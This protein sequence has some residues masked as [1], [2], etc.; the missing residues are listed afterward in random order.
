MILMR[1]FFIFGWLSGL[2]RVF[3]IEVAGTE[4]LD[5]Y[6]GS[7]TALYE[8]FR[9]EV[10]NER[11]RG[12]WVGDSFVYR[13]DEGGKRVY[14]SVNVKGVKELAFDH[15]VMARLISEITGNE[16]KADR[17]PIRRMRGKDGGLQIWVSKKWYAW[18]EG[19]GKL[20]RVKRKVRGGEGG[21]VV[22]P[23]GKWSVRLLGAGVF[24]RAVGDDG[25]GERVLFQG[26]AAEF[27]FGGVTWSPDSK[28]FIVGR[29]AVVEGRKVSF[30]E[31]SPEG[32]LQPKLHEF[33]YDK[34]G[35]KISVTVPWVYFVDGGEVFAPDMELLE[36]PYQ[37][38][39]FG[40]RD[41]DRFTYEFIERG[42]GKHHVIL[43][44]VVAR[45]HVVL[46]REDSETYVHA[47]GGYRYD[48]S[49]GKEIIWSSERDGWRHLYLYDG[50][51]GRVKNQITK[52]EMTLHEVVHVDEVRRRI[53][54]SA[55]GE[56]R[57]RDPYYKHYYWVNFDGGGLVRVT[58]GQDNHE[59]LFS[60]DYRYAVD[61]VCGVNRAP[62][63]RVIDVDTGE[64]MVELGDCDLGRIRD[65]GWQMP[66]PFMAKDRDGR[67]EVWGAI[68]RPVGF[69][70]KKKYP[71][72]EYIYAGP[73]D[74]H[75]PKV[76]RF[77]NRGIHEL[78]MRGFL[79]VRID[80]KGTNKRCR[81]FSHFCYKNIV[82]AG[83]PDRIKWIREAGKRYPEMDLSRVGIFGG[84]AGGQNS[85]G[86]LLHHGDFYKAAFSDCGCHD[87]RMDKIWWNEQ[88][89]D[90]PV[91]PHYAEQSNV[92]NAGKLQGKLFLTVGELDRNV[93]PASTMQLVDALVKAGK[94]FDFLVMPGMGHGCAESGYGRWRRARFFSEHLVEGGRKKVISG[95]AE[96]L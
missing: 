17:L 67:F 10:R 88:W 22:S 72:I 30:V 5:D 89:M 36:N 96:T 41:D 52:G 76:L 55:G 83:F 74:F 78:T 20:V 65:M 93:D 58:R 81:E 75:V 46:I 21:E 19:G 33:S 53:L 14:Y 25:G 66:E 29:R 80:G 60:D 8:K 92:T 94:D 2:V 4:S 63:Y 84:S 15:E 91:G 62:G 90:W 42:F 6:L 77:W 13:W 40:W 45:K 82:D 54:F 68:Y 71:V 48:V 9:K 34:P 16:V 23:D 70:P 64:V 28:K 49:G 37:I 85:T 11:L 3:A 43:G 47:Y 38:R 50:V 73:H 61:T 39:R 35:D 32:Q 69:D 27:V 44:D 86:A 56:V 18:D 1:V 79:V 7:S 95:E 51:T 57:G 87:N 31:S 59:L 24:L 12:A 26:D